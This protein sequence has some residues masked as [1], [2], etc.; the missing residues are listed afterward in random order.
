VS[1]LET[2]V[3]EA[4]T[5]VQPLIQALDEAQKEC[6][7]AIRYLHNL[8]ERLN[9]DQHALRDVVAALGHDADETQ[10]MLSDQT[11]DATTNLGRVT[12]AVGAATDEWSEVFRKE[13][14]ALAG[15]SSLLS[16]LGPRV[17][18]LAERAE[19]ASHAAL[20]W[21]NAASQQLEEAVEAVEHVVGVGL[22]TMVADWK[23]Q[24]EVSVTRL[25]DYFDKDCEGLLN[26]READ[27][28]S[29]VAQIHEFMD[30]AFEGIA[31][32]DHEVTSYTVEKWGQLTEAQLASTHKEAQTLNE[33]LASLG[34]A[35]TNFEGELQVA[36][37]AIAERQ[38]QAAESAARL[39]QGLFDARGR[40]G[41]FG[42]TA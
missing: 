7:E 8:G 26:T 6:H 9:A 23:H 2:A 27:W 33:A 1:D 15:G 32:H 17:K 13:D 4:V 25:V 14:A 28:K 18:D 38:Q 20:E 39:E 40:W 34:Q 10:H 41:T 3:H 11:A 42:I 5:Q 36:S 37:D 24:V 12:E 19:S 35:A 29:K 31:V 22:T 16:E 30:H 21:A